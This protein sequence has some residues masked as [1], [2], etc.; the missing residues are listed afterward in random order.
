MTSFAISASDI[1]NI[2][3]RHFDVRMTSYKNFIID[4]GFRIQNIPPYTKF[5]QDQANILANMQ[6]LHFSIP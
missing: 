3:S 6:V 4:F 2:P 1:G 5:E